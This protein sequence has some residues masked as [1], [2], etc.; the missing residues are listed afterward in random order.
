MTE[1][2]DLPKYQK[3]VQIL[4]TCAKRGRLRSSFPSGYGIDISDIDIEWLFEK[5]VNLGADL[6]AVPRWPPRKGWFIWAYNFQGRIVGTSLDIDEQGYLKVWNRNELEI[7][8]APGKW[9]FVRLNQEET[10]KDG[11][12]KEPK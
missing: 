2:Y 11:K 10:K 7:Q 12:E 9:S 4:E 8:I 1:I 3:L 5:L 6:E